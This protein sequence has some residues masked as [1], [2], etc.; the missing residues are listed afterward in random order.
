M[1][2]LWL[3]KEADDEEPCKT[4]EKIRTGSK[5]RLTHLNT[6]VNLHSH[7]VQSPLSN[8]QEVTGF[9][10]DGDGDRGD[11]W[12]VVVNGSGGSGYW[13]EALLGMGFGCDCC[14]DA[15]NVATLVY[16]AFGC[17]KGTMG[18]MYTM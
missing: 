2:N 11:D 7:N 5:I 12:V 9:G 4:G 15:R 1:D 8:Q 17:H 10:E 16:F 3:V 6:G 14:V 18:P 13:V